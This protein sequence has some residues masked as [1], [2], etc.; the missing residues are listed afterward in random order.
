MTDKVKIDIQ[1]L[2]LEAAQESASD[3]VVVGMQLAVTCLHDIAN[4]AVQMNDVAL[5]EILDTLCLV[6]KTEIVLQ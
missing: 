1:M 5:L 3:D 4:R 2:M 6:K